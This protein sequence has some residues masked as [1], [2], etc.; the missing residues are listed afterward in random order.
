MCFNLYGPFLR[1]D[2]VPFYSAIDRW[3]FA[4]PRQSAQESLSRLSGGGGLDTA[5]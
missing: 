3:E 4:R 1:R 5:E 2:L